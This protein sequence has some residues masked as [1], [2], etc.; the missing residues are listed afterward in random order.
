MPPPKSKRLMREKGVTYLFLEVELSLVL[1]RLRTM[2]NQMGRNAHPSLE[3]KR[4][5]GMLDARR[6][7][8]RS[9]RPPVLYLDLSLVAP[10]VL[11]R[12]VAER[13]A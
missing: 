12:T 6:Q 11:T 4:T 1:R 10:A 7:Q 13:N 9:A 3:R 2:K 8:R 5:K